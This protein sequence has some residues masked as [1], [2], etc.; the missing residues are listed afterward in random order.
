MI[1]IFEFG[2]IWFWVLMS[3]VCI[4]LMAVQENA[5][6]PGRWSTFWVAA[7]LLTLYYCGAGLT[8]KGLG[9]YI[10]HNVGETLVNFGL[11]VVFGVVWS[12]FKWGFMVHDQVEIYNKKFDNR[13]N[14]SVKWNAP[15]LDE[16]KG[17]I[18]NWIFYWPFSMTWFLIHEPIER[19]YAF[20]MRYTGRVYE[21]ITN[22]ASKRIKVAKDDMVHK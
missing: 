18:F 14:Y 15:K 22:R 19:L 13:P 10:Y 2:T 4:V 3:L 20:I 7:T 9:L 5:K 1:A 8:I 6:S 21:G 11:Y 17:I 16:Y 12:F